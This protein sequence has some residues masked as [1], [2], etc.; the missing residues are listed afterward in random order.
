MT[1][2]NFIRI[3][4]LC[5][6]YTVKEPSAQCVISESLK[7]CAARYIKANPATLYLRGLYCGKS[8]SNQL[9]ISLLVLKTS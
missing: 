3:Y 4:N 1:K 9:L 2:N 5:A 7:R 8:A 6:G